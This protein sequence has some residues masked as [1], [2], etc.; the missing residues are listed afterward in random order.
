MANRA[1]RRKRD[2][3]VADPASIRPAF[4]RPLSF[5]MIL[6]VGYGVAS[7][8]V[9]DV[10]SESRGRRLDTAKAARHRATRA[11]DNVRGKAGEWKGWILETLSG[12]KTKTE[13]GASKKADIALGHLPSPRIRDEYC[14]G[15]RDCASAAW[16]RESAARCSLD[17]CLSTSN[18]TSAVIRNDPRK[19]A[20]F[21]DF[22][23]NAT[24]TRW[25]WPTKQ[26][27]QL[28][29]DKRFGQRRCSVVGGA[30]FSRNT[31]DRSARIDESELTIRVNLALP[32]KHQARQQQLQGKSL[33]GD[34]TLGLGT[35]TDVLVLNWIALKKWC[36]T[37]YN[38]AAVNAHLAGVT[39][40]V[41]IHEVEHIDMFLRCKEDLRRAKSDIFLVPLHP[42]VRLED[43]RELQRTLLSSPE[44][45][46]KELFPGARTPQSIPFATTGLSAVNVALR[47]CGSVRTFGLRGDIHH[48]LKNVVYNPTSFHALAV[49]RLTLN[50][51]RDCRAL[52]E[53]GL[54]RKLE[55][56]NR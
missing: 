1:T 48:T 56:F 27:I 43:E 44:A 6:L 47:I 41:M 37:S 53:G 32:L 38:N 28:H 36:F 45:K 25:G 30:P 10:G 18:W 42:Q 12:A 9:D 29:F 22:L 35:R 49:E 50:R 33:S 34:A 39:M 4:F 46:R 24:E 11:L 20:R 54:C 14:S 19:A 55:E 51:V 8:V 23:A 21:E 40:L 3:N 13:P 31:T 17:Q 15:L 52:K 7:L 26:A 2:S 16:S 5:L